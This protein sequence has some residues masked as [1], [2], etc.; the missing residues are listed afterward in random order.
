MYIDSGDSLTQKAHSRSKAK[1]PSIF[2]KESSADKSEV[3]KSY[4]TN[5]DE[6]QVI[7][8]DGYLQDFK[9][10]FAYRNEK[11]LSQYNQIINLEH[12]LENFARGYEKYGIFVTDKGITYR[13]WA[14]GAKEMYLFGD[15]NNWDK[16]QHPMIR[17]GFG[18]WTITLNN[19]AKGEAPIAH[20]SRIKAWVLT[21]NNEW[22]ARIPAWI[23]YAVQE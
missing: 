20:G 18:N 11:F 13:E 23:R 17:D 4:V 1:K 12:S 3:M 16:H 21:A 10:H 14:P 7:R 6:L 9:A 8:D 2:Y 22:V 5:V 15:F 19:N